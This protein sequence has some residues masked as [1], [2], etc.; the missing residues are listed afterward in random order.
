MDPTQRFSSRV[1]HYVRY[2]PG[3]PVGVVELLRVECGLTP[4]W[5]VADV[6]AGTG[7]LTQPLLEHGNRVWAVEPNGDM[8]QA[9]ERLLG[10][11]PGFVS[12]AGRAEATTLPSASIDLI[13]AGQAFHWFEP[14]PTRAEFTRILRPGGWVALVWNERLTETTPFLRAYED[15]LVRYATDYDRV[16]HRLVADDPAIAAFFQTPVSKHTLPNQQRFDLEGVRG[17]LLSSSYAPEA[18]HPNY[19][20]MLTELER[21]FAQH[22]QEGVVVFEYLTL[23]YLAR[24]HT[25][26]G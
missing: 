6:G 7:L 1:D 17:R 18:D 13:T 9:A 5:V 15:L 14:A 20:P 22:A 12:V 23:V 26:G 10:S 24:L 25:D 16:D 3:Y 2:R 21:L 8:R 4:T 19:A 11:R